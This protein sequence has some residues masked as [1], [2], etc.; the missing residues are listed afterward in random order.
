MSEKKPKEIEM[1]PLG[2]TKREREIVILMT[3]HRHPMVT[4]LLRKDVGLPARGGNHPKTIDDVDTIIQST[5]AY[6]FLNIESMKG[7]CKIWDAVI[8][9][10]DH[11]LKLKS[12]GDRKGI[13]RFLK[14][15]RDPYVTNTV[16]GDTSKSIYS[17]G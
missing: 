12:V 17:D 10:W 15:L 5:E 7:F 3:A 8:A 16:T 1:K 11:I 13:A 6:S 9:Q 2:P 4:A 14:E